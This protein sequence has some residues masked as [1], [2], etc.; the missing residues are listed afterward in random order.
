[1][2]YKFFLF[3]K[4]ILNGVGMRREEGK[5]EKNKQKEEKGKEKKENLSLTKDGAEHLSI[6]CYLESCFWL[7]PMYPP[8]H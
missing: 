1:M 4:L 2:V 3:S 8:C 6:P 5:R 7:I